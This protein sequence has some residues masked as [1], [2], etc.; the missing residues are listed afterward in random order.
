[1][2]I[3][4]QSDLNS[5]LEELRETRDEAIEWING[6]LSRYQMDQSVWDSTL[7]RL[8]AITGNYSM[9]LEQYNKDL[10]Y[11]LKAYTSANSNERT[12]AAPSFFEAEQFIGKDVIE[13]P[14]FDIPE[15]PDWND[16]PGRIEE[17]F[18]LIGDKYDELKKKFQM[19]NLA[20]DRQT[21]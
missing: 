14:Q 9:N 18:E 16:V 19:L 17:G 7:N 20:G 3:R 1:M 13:V 21:S 11:L 15:T 5:A 4:Y 2:R 8:Q 6:M 10:A 12:T